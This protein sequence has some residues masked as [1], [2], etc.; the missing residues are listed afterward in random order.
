MT[1]DNVHEHLKY[2]LE[3]FPIETFHK[4]EYLIGL[5]RP[6]LQSSLTRSTLSYHTYYIPM[7]VCST[8]IKRMKKKRFWEFRHIYRGP[9]LGQLYCTIHRTYLC[10]YIP[11][12][13]KEWKKWFCEFR[14]FYTV[15]W[16]GQLYRS[17]IPL[18]WKEGKNE[19]ENPSSQ[20]WKADL[21]KRLEKEWSKEI[22]SLRSGAIVILD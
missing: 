9:W 15:P 5:L 16:L 22:S 2:Q 7:F 14:H 19:F 18:W 21:V 20:S 11:L 13:W 10:S 3:V 6:F 8:L 17:Y 1:I 4:W 12:W